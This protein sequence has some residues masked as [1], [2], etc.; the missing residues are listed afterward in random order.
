MIAGLLQAS[1]RC[2]TALLATA[3]WVSVTGVREGVAIAL[4]VVGLVLIRVSLDS[5]RYDRIGGGALAIM[6]PTVPW[7]GSQLLLVVGLTFFALRRV[8][9]RTRVL[10]TELA[11][12]LWLAPF[13]GYLLGSV[14][15]EVC[16]ALGVFG[17]HRTSIAD[18]VRI[19][20]VARVF[21]LLRAFVD[22]HVSSWGMLARVVLAGWSIAFVTQR[23]D[24]L[25]RGVWW[26]KRATAFSAFFVFAQWFLAQPF[27]SAWWVPVSLALP[28]QTPI[29]D[30]LGRPSGLATDPNALGVVMALVL[31]IAALVPTTH[32]PLQLGQ[33]RRY[34]WWLLI[35]AAGVVSGSR[36][37]LLSAGVLGIAALWRA[38]GRR[39]ALGGLWC[40]VVLVGLVTAIDSYSGLVAHLVASEGVPMGIRR[41]VAALSLVRIEET[42]MSRSVFLEFA[43]AIGSG[44]WLFGV[45]ADRFIDYVPLVGAER[46]LVRG[47]RDNSNNFYLG[48]LV[49]IGVVGAV[50]FA[51]V[52]LGR[53]CRHQPLVEAG[54]GQ[55]SGAALLMLAVIGCTGP[56]TDFT[57]VLML[58]AALIA[59][60]TTERRS[61]EFGYRYVTVLCTAIGAVAITFHER[62]VY[63]WSDTG[64]G[65]TRWL[66]HVA[67]V[68]L[69]CSPSDAARGQARLVL[70][71]R[72]IPQTEPL[73]VTVAPAGQERQE[74]LFQAAQEREVRVPCSVDAKRVFVR[75]TT[76]PA[77]SPY[78]AWPR[79]S[80]D[81]RI[82]GVEQG[83]ISK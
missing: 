8:P 45:G 29:W 69:S 1:A 23:S 37:F 81:R 22:V 75:V 76:S 53:C 51:C 43:R 38:S 28:N 25:M 67:T 52:V 34:L 24:L 60:T 6:L 57:E 10:S 72:Y 20:G 3:A 12:S 21:D 47:W 14:G 41:G 59:L 44:R 73:K 16:S 74:V 27:I 80:Q 9:V 13:M 19:D 54:R 49:E 32:A 62:G 68:E 35:I 31:W 36:T 11:S 58:V 42:V 71:P 30:A 7:L 2:L 79:V 33:R 77:W 39:L 26:L 64:A 5:E 56:H 70:K 82:L 15:C 83:T 4:L 65:A 55:F 61:I 66:S 63:G 50:A 78:R 48:L 18:S 40:I 46:N 17:F